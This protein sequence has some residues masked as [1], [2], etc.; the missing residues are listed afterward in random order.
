[1]D[2]NIDIQRQ[3]PTVTLLSKQ[4]VTGE[5]KAKLFSRKHA[6]KRHRHPPNSIVCIPSLHIID[7]QLLL[8]QK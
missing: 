2:V 6:T 1:M 5:E 8:W 4:T 3:Q 7:Y